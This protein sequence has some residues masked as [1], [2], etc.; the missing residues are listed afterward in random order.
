LTPKIT[1]KEFLGQKISGVLGKKQFYVSNIDYKKGIVTLVSE[2]RGKEVKI[3][4]SFR[5]FQK[6]IDEGKYQVEPNKK[7]NEKTNDEGDVR[8]EDVTKDENEAREVR[9]DDAKEQ[10]KEVLGE[11]GVAEKV[12]PA[13]AEIE[14]EV[15]LI[16]DSI[17]EQFPSKEPI[18]KSRSKPTD[19]KYIEAIDFL[20]KQKKSAVLIQLLKTVHDRAK[21]D[22]YLN[23]I[24][25]QI[26][27]S[28]G[29]VEALAEILQKYIN[30]S[31]SLIEKMIATSENL[32]VDTK[33]KQFDAILGVPV[34]LW[35][36]A[37][38]T[39]VLSLKAGKKISQA[40][41]EA[42]ELIKDYVSE[43]D[44]K[45]YL[46]EAGID[47]NQ[48]DAPAQEVVE[49]N[50][51][52]EVKAEP[53][54]EAE[55]NRIKISKHFKTLDNN[56]SLSELTKDL[57]QL[58]FEYQPVSMKDDRAVAIDYLEKNGLENT[59]E[60]FLGENFK[61]KS[62]LTPSQQV[63]VA[64]LLYS[65]MHQAKKQAIK[66]G[67]ISLADAI[68]DRMMPLVKA[69]TKIG[70]EA[71]RM[72]N[73]FKAFALDFSDPQTAV[74][75][76]Q[77]HID[78]INE[79]RENSSAVK[80]NSED[81]AKD[82]NET[83][84]KGKKKTTK[85]VETIL[86]E[87]LY[88]AVTKGV[89]KN[90]TNA[91]RKKVSDFFDSLLADEN[92]PV[93]ATVVPI[94]PKMYNLFVKGVKALVLSGVDLGIA[95][96]KVSA[97]MIKDKE[98]SPKELLEARK[99]FKSKVEGIKEKKPLTDKQ[100]ERKAEAEK[101][102]EAT[103]E[104]NA[105]KEI[106]DYKEKQQKK[107]ESLREKDA[108]KVLENVEKLELQRAQQQAKEAANL[109]DELA[110]ERQKIADLKAKEA[111]DLSDKVAKLEL[112][113][114]QNKLKEIEAAIKKLVSD[115]PK[116]NQELAKELVDEYVAMSPTDKINN[117]KLID[118]IKEKLDVDDIQ[119]KRIATEIAKGIKENV[120]KKLENKYASQLSSE[121][122]AAKAK[123]VTPKTNIIDELITASNTGVTPQ[124]VVEYL[125]NKYG[126]AE[127]TSSDAD[128]ILEIAKQVGEAPTKNRKG[129]LL[130][131]IQ[132][133]IDSKKKKTLAELFQNL[134]YARVLSPVLGI[135]T[136]TGDVNIAYN[137]ATTLLNAKEYPI[138]VS[139][140]TGKY[141]KDAIKGKNY[142]EIPDIISGFF[143]DMANGFLKST[144]Q[145]YIYDDATTANMDK[146]INLLK[147]SKFLM[148]QSI[149]Y[150]KTS[151]QEGTN[152]Q[153]DY[154][155]PFKATAGVRFD[156]ANWNSIFK[157]AE[158]GD[159]TA[160]KKIAE[161][162]GVAINAYV[163]GV[164]NI[165]SGQDLFFG[166][167]LSNAYSVPLTREKYYKEG[168]RGE[169]L[170]KKVIEDV[171]STKLEYENAKAQ[172]VSFRMKY[173]I[174]INEKI[175]SSGRNISYE[176]KDK[177]KLKGTFPSMY[178]ADTFAKDVVAPK[179]NTFN[180]DVIYLMNQKMGDYVY[181][182]A[183][184]IARNDLLSGGVEGTTGTLLH[185]LATKFIN[186]LNKLSESF[187]EVSRELDQYDWADIAS[188]VKGADPMALKAIAKKVVSGIIEGISIITRSFSNLLA[189]IRVGLNSIRNQSSYI[190][191]I[192]IP[193][194]LMSFKE[195]DEKTRGA[196]GGLMSY[197]ISDVERSK[198]L[199]KAI[200]GSVM[201]AVSSTLS[202]AIK[203][204]MDD[205]DD[206]K[207][208]EMKQSRDASIIKFKEWYKKTTGTEISKEIETF[209]SKLYEGQIIG[210]L[211]WMPPNQ[212]M[213]YQRTGLLVE[214]SKFVG[215]DE[216]G[217][218]KFESVKN[219]PEQALNLIV[220]TYKLVEAF[221]DEKDKEQA[222]IYAA[223]T[224]LYSWKD[225]SIGQGGISVMFG[226]MSA[227]E[228]AKKLVQIA[229]L[230]NF[231]VL[232]PSLI[233]VGLQYYDQKMRRN[234]NLFD[235]IESEGSFYGGV[236]SWMLNRVMPVYGAYSQAMKSDQI[237][238]MFGEELYRIPA[239]SQGLFSSK[240]AEYVKSDKNPEEQKMY[241]W[242]DVNGYSKVWTPNKEEPIYGKDGVPKQLTKSQL[243]KY[244]RI[245][246]EKSKEEIKS[247][248]AQL[249]AIRDDR[250][251]TPDDRIKAFTKEIDN[252]FRKNFKN[253]YYEQENSF[254]SQT[255]EI[256]T[257]MDE[258]YNENFKKRTEKYAEKSE[259]DIQR[260]INQ[261]VTAEEK[262]DRAK[263]KSIDQY[264]SESTSLNKAEIYDKFTRL[265]DIG[266][267]T[268]AQYK[269]AMES[270]G[271]NY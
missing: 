153:K 147:N 224:P 247:K 164:T 101:L 270:L 141:I 81:I 70:T 59:L 258:V 79:E 215:Y 75:N 182:N 221:G 84:D 144:L 172:A 69:T 65:A 170:N 264:M 132:E 34:A 235:A 131:K 232:N 203:D 271:V 86:D 118:L 72:V 112:Q 82:I 202:N 196:L 210:N 129:V 207:V 238:G 53:K 128:T 134:F 168:Y 257:K 96:T 103:K 58:D 187:N 178:E 18:K 185:G 80:K 171:L 158:A 8:K 6:N 174:T 77:K 126:I 28:D 227:E 243:N 29:S 209:Y 268:D 263:D 39:I 205:D 21:I 122:R 143:S 121:E 12:A 87:E 212:K 89:K 35:N 1:N 191:L 33:N 60:L 47:K 111:T 259:K 142:K 74:Y 162:F 228:K 176:V 7:T 11:A 135:F 78:K 269:Y 236:K 266:S 239:E 193:R 66:D 108:K 16:L 37:M 255:K 32:K 42:Y 267:I 251:E 256:V 156:I 213:F 262:A 50:P 98:G 30:K 223:L 230:D 180:N 152:F 24:G 105:E 250:G 140:M 115:I 54:N 173:D 40:V 52:E 167:I 27:K 25:K 49:E 214:N 102:K 166:S 19:T 151:L 260:D 253:A 139:V 4:N 146:F 124:L 188:M 252:I 51:K 242:L 44:F 165:L 99:L 265:K 190:P 20:K 114:A 94:T 181:D 222:R 117:Q 199:S 76:M 226:N 130:G 237:Y 231:E 56:E 161:A 119:A 9:K 107:A 64:A 61:S 13:K 233:R 67:D 150:F 244:G 154:D 63:Q 104:Y 198:I 234:E 43:S 241:M 57:D 136:G 71:G 110:K 240:L 248:L 10:V 113:R 31:E 169:E 95:M 100:K 249:Q 137:F 91:T 85:K 109:Q 254:G 206:E 211:S 62:G 46:V 183:N 229:V 133:L 48:I 14:N 45:S 55:S 145:E 97:Q 204:A 93:M 160:Q 125:K 159:K 127:L 184:R 88:G 175:D 68:H 186:E 90:A 23:E 194:Y 217:K 83:V 163:N 38:D 41:S 22:S 26:L 36:T 123:G 218:P 245:A 120:R 246:G 116:T 155:N 157:K 73:A 189:F 192:G 225:M 216:N 219:K 17:K 148:R 200:I 261:G 5:E 195:K 138:T 220:S 149:N 2:Y 179:G 92:S 177:G 106:A 201:F 208:K 3:E 197:K 15:D